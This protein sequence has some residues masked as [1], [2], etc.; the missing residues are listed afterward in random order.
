MCSVGKGT[1]CHKLGDKIWVIWVRGRFV[2]N[3]RTKAGFCV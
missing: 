3:W 2:M 1:I